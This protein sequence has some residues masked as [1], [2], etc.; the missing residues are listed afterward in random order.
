MSCPKPA[1]KRRDCMRKT[2]R[3]RGLALFLFLIL[4]SAFATAQVVALGELGGQVR[5]ETGATLPGA[6][7]TATSQERGFTRTTTT[8]STGRFRFSEIQTGR[9]RVTVS[10]SGFSTV[11][12]TDNLVE[13]TKKTDLLVT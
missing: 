6:S 11:N 4:T 8:D 12:M 1:Q 7:V 3:F 2:R 9:Y 5:D 13:N 10:L